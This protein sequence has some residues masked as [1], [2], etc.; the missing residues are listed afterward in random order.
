MSEKAVLSAI[1]LIYSEPAETKC[2]LFC[3]ESLIKKT[4]KNDCLRY[5]VYTESVLY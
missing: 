5:H 4:N 3:A 2:F 1:W